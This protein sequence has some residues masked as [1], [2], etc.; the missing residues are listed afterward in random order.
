MKCEKKMKISGWDGTARL[1][2]EIMFDLF[3][4]QQEIQCSWIR[5]MPG[6]SQLFNISWMWNVTS[7]VVTY[8][9]YL[10]LLGSYF[11]ILWAEKPRKIMLNSL[12][13]S[14]YM[15]FIIFQGT[16]PHRSPESSCLLDEP[17][18]R[19]Y[20]FNLYILLQLISS[21]FCKSCMLANFPLTLNVL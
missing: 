15:V 11:F 14:R 7:Q 2:G 13:D 8:S 1:W 9:C 20:P 12:L 21:L 3:K 19:T 10:A 4:K 17:D 5:V 16:V 6:M 18:H